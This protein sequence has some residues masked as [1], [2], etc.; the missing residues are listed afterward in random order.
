MLKVFYKIPSVRDCKQT[1]AVKAFVFFKLVS[2]LKSEE[3]KNFLK[4]LDEVIWEPDQ[5]FM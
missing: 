5:R 4:M 2:I 1:S 3:K